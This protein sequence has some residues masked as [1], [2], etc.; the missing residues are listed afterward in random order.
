MVSCFIRVPTAG[1]EC[2]T[3]SEGFTNKV[4]RLHSI[5]I[6]MMGLNQFQ[7]KHVRTR[8]NQFSRLDKATPGVFLKGLS[9]TLPDTRVSD[10]R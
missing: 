6:Y 3:R 4:S 10:Y 2:E 1:K 5:I 8:L 9:G 7:G